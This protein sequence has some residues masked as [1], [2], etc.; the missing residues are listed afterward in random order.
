MKTWEE[1]WRSC[2][3]GGELWKG[4]ASVRDLKTPEE[5]EREK[6]FATQDDLEVARSL[7]SYVH[8]ARGALIEDDFEGYQCMMD[9]AQEYAAEMFHRAEE[10]ISYTQTRIYVYRCGCQKSDTVPVTFK[11]DAGSR[12][13]EQAGRCL[14]CLRRDLQTRKEGRRLPPG[15]IRGTR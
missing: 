6:F 11:R 10:R 2:L 13:I 3:N 1:V 14:D 15:M 9:A 8:S 12:I 5:E 7:Q 4:Y